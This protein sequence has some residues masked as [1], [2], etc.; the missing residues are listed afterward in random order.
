MKDIFKHVPQTREPM[1]SSF[2]TPA[3][4]HFFCDSI[5]GIG[6]NE[7]ALVPTGYEP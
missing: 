6:S 1:K 2:E 4:T 3:R 5:G 7:Q